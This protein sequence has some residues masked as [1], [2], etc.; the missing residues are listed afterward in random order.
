LAVAWILCEDGAARVTL[1]MALAD[2]GYEDIVAF[3]D[4]RQLV[5]HVAD[6]DPSLAVVDVETV[7]FDRHAVHA[8][9]AAASVVLLTAEDDGGPWSW[10]GACSVAKPDS[11]DDLGRSVMRILGRASN[12][13]LQSVHAT[14]R[15]QLLV[16][17]ERRR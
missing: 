2:A 4:P 8:R 16:G 10:P 1:A 12:T 17:R 14:P 3:E 11:A 9:L 7:R 6:V 15:I 5:E 13:R